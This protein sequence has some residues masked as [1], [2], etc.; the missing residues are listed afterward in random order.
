MST[1]LPNTPTPK[2]PTADDG[3]VTPDNFHS[4]GIE[5]AASEG[6]LA[7]TTPTPTVKPNNFHSDGT[8]K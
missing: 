2:A 5:Q 7:P 1:E 6:L 3:T 4:D 8:T